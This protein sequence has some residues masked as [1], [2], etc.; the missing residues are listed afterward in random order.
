TLY[1]FYGRQMSRTT[2]RP[3]GDIA[4]HNWQR[5]QN[6]EAD[7]LLDQLARTSDGTEQLRLSHALQRVFVQNA[8]ALP[9]FPGP[10]FG[11]YVSTRIVGFP[12]SRDPYT[13][14]APYKTPGNLL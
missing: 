10:A 7:A 8:P 12:D 3:I 5:Y 11:E 1:T 9:L 14:L 13:V 2:Y 6:E 4:D